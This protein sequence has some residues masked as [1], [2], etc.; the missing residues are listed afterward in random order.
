M[1]LSIE[2]TEQK[3]GTLLVAI[4]GELMLGP[5]CNQLAQFL[6]GQTGL[7][8]HV[9]FDVAGISQ[10]DSTGIGLFIDAYSRLEKAGGQ[11]TIA[12]AAGAVKDAFHVTRLDTVF[13]FVPTVESA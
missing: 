1:G 2:S 7:K 9:V 12:G 4:K 3:A 11:M 8:H 10:I 13:R 6:Q 5:D